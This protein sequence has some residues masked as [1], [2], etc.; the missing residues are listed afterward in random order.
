MKFFYT[1]AVKLQSRFDASKPGKHTVA[2][3]IA[4]LALSMMKSTISGN[5]F[6]RAKNGIGGFYQKVETV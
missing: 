4:F 1:A 3:S 2:Y 6:R 5:Q